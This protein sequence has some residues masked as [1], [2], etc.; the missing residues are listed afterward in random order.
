MYAK[1]RSPNQCSLGNLG[2]HKNLTPKVR[3]T[4]GVKTFRSPI[5]TE[6]ELI[7]TKALP[8]NKRMF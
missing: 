5:K 6:A 7:C 1:H 8:K 3:A 4:A 2:G